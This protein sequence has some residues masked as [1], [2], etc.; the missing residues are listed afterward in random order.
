MMDRWRSFS[1]DPR[2]G[3]KFSRVSDGVEKKNQENGPSLRFERSGHRRGAEVHSRGYEEPVQSL[4][5]LLFQAGEAEDKSTSG[6][7]RTEQWDTRQE[8][9]RCQR[10]HRGRHSKS[11]RRT[12]TKYIKYV[13]HF[14]N[15][16]HLF[17]MRL[18]DCESV[19]S[20]GLGDMRK[21][22]GEDASMMT[23]PNA[24]RGTRSI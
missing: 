2:Q 24:G 14:H 3:T 20:L 8:L 1:R 18:P 9:R 23:G 21:C 4:N 15:G 16:R 17:C 22:V 10:W 12:G 19:R 13:F 11:R 5:R 6:Q 7:S